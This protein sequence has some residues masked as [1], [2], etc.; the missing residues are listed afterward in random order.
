MIRSTILR[1]FIHTTTSVSSRNESIRHIEDR[2]I[3][4]EHAVHGGMIDDVQLF[5]LKLCVELRGHPAQ[6]VCTPHI[7]CNFTTSP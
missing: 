5:V 1:K 4:D 6:G 7:A 3:L 2:F